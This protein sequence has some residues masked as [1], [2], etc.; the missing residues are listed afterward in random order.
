MWSDSS[1]R[2]PLA[3]YAMSGMDIVQPIAPSIFNVVF[4][5]HIHPTAGVYA[6]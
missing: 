5:H 1:G 6:R 3:A 2:D 4:P